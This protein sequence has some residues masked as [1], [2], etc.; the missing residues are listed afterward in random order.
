MKH[1]F[2]AIS[3]KISKMVEVPEELKSE[4]EAFKAAHLLATEQKKPQLVELEGK[5]VVVI[6]TGSGREAR[7]F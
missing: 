3:K 6:D 5:K 4:M 1:T 7:P 2:T